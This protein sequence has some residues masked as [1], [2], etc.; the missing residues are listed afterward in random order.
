MPEAAE[1][2]DAT[3]EPAAREPRR[4]LRTE[5]G[6]KL[7]PRFIPLALFGVGGTGLGLH[8]MTAVNPLAGSVQSPCPRWRPGR[9]P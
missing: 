8:L 2:T 7:D 3:P 6:L 1:A 5:G 4:T 9:S